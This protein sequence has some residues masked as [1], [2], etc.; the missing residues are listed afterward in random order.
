MSLKNI[1]NYNLIKTED[2]TLTIYHL[3][4]VLLVLLVTKLIIMGIKRVLIMQSKRK[5]IDIGKSYA[6]IQLIKYFLWILAIII[7]FDTIGLKITILLAGSA[8]LLVGL[9]LGLQQIFQ[10][11]VAGISILFEGTL[12][13]DDVVEIEGEIVGKVTEIGLRTSKIETRDNIIMIVPNSR[14][15]NDN[16]INWS[17]SQ[18]KTR[19]NVSVGVAYGSDVDKVRN[20][21]V[22]CAEKHPDVV[23]S[24]KPFVKFTDFGESSLDFQLLFWTSKT[25]EVEKIKSDLRFMIDAGFRENGVTIPFPQRDVHIIPP[26]E[27]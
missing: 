20:I 9:G 3:V 21:L 2:F 7:A 4:I 13:V 23:K 22:N 26:V 14:F 1:L 19:F 27:K 17:H 12:K 5:N 10:D 24:P 25:F 8:A 11:F 6:F 16:V 15:I 18:R